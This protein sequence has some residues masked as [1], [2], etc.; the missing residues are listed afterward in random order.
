[1][2]PTY[3]G[4]LFYESNSNNDWVAAGGPSNIN[5]GNLGT[6]WTN[7]AYL[8]TLDARFKLTNDINFSSFPTGFQFATALEIVSDMR[9]FSGFLEDTADVDGFMRFWRLHSKNSDER[10]YMMVRLGTSTY[11]AFIDDNRASQDYAPGYIQVVE[12]IDESGSPGWTPLQGVFQAVW[13]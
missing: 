2:A 1:M 3:N 9:P 8:K 12:G 10:I 11:R 6:L 5:E 13:S 7:Y 4:V